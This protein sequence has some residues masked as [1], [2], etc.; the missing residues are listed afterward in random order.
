[1]EIDFDKL[2][3]YADRRR[4]VAIL[5]PNETDIYACAHRLANFLIQ[6]QENYSFNWTPRNSWIDSVANHSDRRIRRR[7][8]IWLQQGKIGFRG[9]VKYLFWLANNDKYK[10]RNF[11]MHLLSI[12]QPK[13]DL[14]YLITNLTKS[15][16]GVDKAINWANFKAKPD[17]FENPMTRAIDKLVSSEEEYL[18][19]LS[20]PEVDIPRMGGWR[21]TVIG[22]HEQD[23]EELEIYTDSDLYL[24][25]AGGHHTPWYSNRF[26]VPFVSLDLDPPWPI[27]SVVLR[28]IDNSEG[29]RK[30]RAMKDQKLE[31]Y[32]KKLQ[33]QAWQRWDLYKDPLPIDQ[34]NKITIISSGFLTS[35]F[36]P[37][38]EHFNALLQTDRP[39]NVIQ[40]FKL[41]TKF[42][43]MM[44]LIK[45]LE[46]VYQG[47]TVE[48]ITLSR[49]SKYMTK[50]RLC[51]IRWE[52]QEMVY[53]DIKEHGHKITNPEFK[54]KRSAELLV[55]IKNKNTSGD[56]DGL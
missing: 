44:G 25:L 49:P 15:A 17:V 34:A 52:N 39:L 7:M 28:Y 27:N 31:Q 56:E 23:L 4:N 36:T 1:M 2:Y 30:L 53:F 37:P 24:D 20:L 22:W 10:A 46:P 41:M 9:R 55:N 47:K 16:Y 45:I 32:E 14:E 48:L 42:H 26:G 33:E 18:R 29:E 54:Q 13:P 40:R 21:N 3:E 43:C 38:E 5:N 6:E 51:H 12:D 35:T 11:I 50:H 8:K 19:V